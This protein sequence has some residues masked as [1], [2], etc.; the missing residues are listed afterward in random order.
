MLIFL[1]GFMGSGKSYAARN[2]SELLQIPFVDTDKAI[3]AAEGMT[4][5]EIFEQKGE[6]YFRNLERAY[7]SGLSPDQSLIVATGGG[8]PCF[9]DNMQVMNRKGLT[10]FLNRSRERA[11][12][13]LLKGIE[14]R[15]LLQDKNEEQIGAFYDEKL[16]ERMPFYAEAEIHAGDADIEELAG[17]IKAAS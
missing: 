14:K 3:E 4:V 5:K 15:P 7:L 11:L 6:A 10:I 17:L 12:A 2:L 1:I 13:Q 16:A 9:F 8:M